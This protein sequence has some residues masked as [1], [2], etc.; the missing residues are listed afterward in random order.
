VSKKR[1]ETSAWRH[2]GFC[3]YKGERIERDEV[4]CENNIEIVGKPWNLYG[5][6]ELAWSG[7]Y[8]HRTWCMSCHALMCT[9]DTEPCWESIY[10]KKPPSLVGSMRHLLETK[11]CTLEKLVVNSLNH[12]RHKMCQRHY[13]L[14]VETICSRCD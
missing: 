14:A 6:P 12:A 7:F 9:P 13:R 3:R 5:R 10:Q 1:T 11:G 2:I 8:Q 4:K